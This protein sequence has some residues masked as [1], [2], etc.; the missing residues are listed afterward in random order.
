MIS[1]NDK[2]RIAGKKREAL[3]NLKRSSQKRK[4]TEVQMLIER[5]KKGKQRAETY[6]PELKK[7]RMIEETNVLAQE[8]LSKR[9][10][11]E[12]QTGCAQLACSTHKGTSKIGCKYYCLYC[13]LLRELLAA[14]RILANKIFI[15][16]LEKR[17]ILLKIVTFYFFHLRPN[18]HA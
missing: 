5:E 6:P 13:W 15:P 10:K 7:R 1:V 12:G 9:Q 2:E 14:S 3:E 11:T 16:P 17:K 8:G 18:V 4:A